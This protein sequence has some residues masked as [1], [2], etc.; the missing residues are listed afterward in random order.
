MET[1]RVYLRRGL[2]RTSHIEPVKA[3]RPLPDFWLSVAKAGESDCWLWTKGKSPTGY[4]SCRTEYGSST[5]SRAAYMLHHGLTRG[6]VAGKLVCHTCDNRLCCNPSHLWLGSS[7]ENS[8]D[9][10]RKRRVFMN[11]APQI[12]MEVILAAKA[13]R[14]LADSHGIKPTRLA[15]I[16]VGRSYQWV[17]T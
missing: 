2:R 3:V 17:D 12:P 4:G 7:M 15:A 13:L 11:G 5:A 8:A 16:L 9:C 1:N 6:D 10:A 14:T